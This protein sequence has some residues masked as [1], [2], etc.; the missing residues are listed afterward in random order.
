[1]GKHRHVHLVV[2]AGGSGTRFWPL[3]RRARPKQ[4]IDLTGAGSLLART[5]ARV[6]PLAP[7]SRSWM[8]VGTHHAGACQADVPEVPARHVLVE[9]VAK[10]TAAAVGLA[11]V[12]VRHLEPDAVMLVLPADHHV[13]DEVAF[14]AALEKAVALADEGA[15]AT[16]GIRPTHPETGYGYIQRGA[17]HA[18]VEGAYAVE[19]FCEKP[20]LEKAR[21][22]LEQGHFDWNAGI[23]VLRPDRFLDEA[24]RQ[25]PRLHAALTEVADA[26]GHDSYDV[27]LERAYAR[28]DSISIDHGIMEGARDVAVV[29]VSCGWSDVGSWSALGAV[30][31]ADA[32]GNVVRG[33]TALVDTDGTIVYSA[34]DH[35]V[36]VV[37]MKDVVVVHTDEA[38]LV[39]PKDRAQDVRAIIA[40]LEERGQ[41]EYL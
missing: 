11:A 31:E 36:G 24:A 1:M 26:I 25:L 22:F 27:V 23:F 13:K 33:D 29:P 40:L 17:A 8:V 35:M 38:T 7:A 20:N 19:R 12:H 37:G 3:S 34:P 2:M 21:S 18:R 30:V 5:F 28:L 16:L 14:L 15:I 32:R 9:P 41:G 10:N 39:V 4:L 6:W